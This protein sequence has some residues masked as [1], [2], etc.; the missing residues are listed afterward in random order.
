M[1]ALILHDAL[2]RYFDRDVYAAEQAEAPGMIRRI[3]S[4][5]LPEVTP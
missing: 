5:L 1:S 3:T 2:E 4:D